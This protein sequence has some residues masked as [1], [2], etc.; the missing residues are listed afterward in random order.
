MLSLANVLI[1]GDVISH[2]QALIPALTEIHY[3][4]NYLATMRSNKDQD[5][6]HFLVVE[7]I[8]KYYPKEHIEFGVKTIGDGI[9]FL[10]YRLDIL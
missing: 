2:R 7:Y 1:P 6:F 10:I 8:K 3:T 4:G 5:I 9:D